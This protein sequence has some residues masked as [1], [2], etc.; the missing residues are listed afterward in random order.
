LKPR[1]RIAVTLLLAAVAAVG[2]TGGAA[3]AETPLKIIYFE[4]PPYYYTYKGSA[5]GVLVERTRTIMAEAGIDATFVRMSVKRIINDIREGKTP[6]CSIGWFKSAERE[7]FASFTLP[8]YQNRPLV[9][10][11]TR[12][13]AP[14]MRAYQQMAD[15]MANR[16][17]VLG[18]ISGFSYGTVVD[19]MMA[20]HHPTIE[21]V[22][23]K[24]AQI[25]RMLASGRISYLLLAPEEINGAAKAAGVDPSGLEYIQFID[26]PPGNLRYLMCSQNTPKSVIDDI[27]KAI[28]R[29]RYHR[30]TH[31]Y[32]EEVWDAP[33]DYRP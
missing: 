14:R 9:A 32:P 26:V 1:L 27:N 19:R 17:F 29:I 24:P 6:V 23:G 12:E 7:K 3:V 22:T 2:G 31:R 21:T 13:Q 18:V 10:L 16:S 11:T 28:L 33:P 4:R 15:I 5:Q 30:S 20:I 25:L 8:I